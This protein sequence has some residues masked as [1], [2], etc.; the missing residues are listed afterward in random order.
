MEKPEDLLKLIPPEVL[1]EI[2]KDAASKPLIEASNLGTD[3]IKTGRLL[4]APLQLGSAL[5]DRFS[6][7]LKEK[8]SKI[9]DEKLIE[10]PA[11]IIGPSLEK[12]RYIE[13]DSPLWKMF[14]ELILKAVN[15][16]DIDKAHPSFVHIIGQ[17]S[18]DEALLLYELSK[19]EFEITDTMDLDRVNNRFIN[20]RIEKSTIPKENLYYPENDNLY[21]NHLESL[22]LVSWPVIKETSI[23]SGAN[24]TGTRRISKWV[25]T[26]FGKLFIE[27]CIPEKGFESDSA[28]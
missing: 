20:R 12:M 4:L 28:E 13:E 24:Q 1:K 25:L 14:E 21:Y 18:H 17:L 8:V 3:L 19:G 11:Q 22:S 2:Y 23:G 15:K 9:P 26:D 10:P 16:D 5:Q 6:H 27:A 7:F